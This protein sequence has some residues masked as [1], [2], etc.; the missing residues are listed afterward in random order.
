MVRESKMEVS[1]TL[2][3]LTIGDEYA[4]E[5]TLEYLKLHYI[6]RLKMEKISRQ[7]G[8]SFDDFLTEMWLVA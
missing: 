4:I 6:A 5:M 7:E 2:H 3:D 8:Y 1:N